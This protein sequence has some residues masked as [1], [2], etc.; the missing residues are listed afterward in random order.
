MELKDKIIRSYRMLLSRDSHLLVADANERSITHRLAMYL[1]NEFPEYDI[2]CEYNR[3]GLEPKRLDSFKKQIDSD[4]TNGA[5]V[6]P[7]IIVHHRG[8][9]DNFIVIEAKKS[10]NPRNHRDTGECK[11]DYCK[12]RAYKTDLSYRHAFFIKFPVGDE[13]KQ[14]SYS[15]ITDYIA[16]I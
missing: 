5:T 1:Q 6:F 8:T 4:E 14:L 16:E 7:D 2:D 10:S 13:L 12:L 11:C 9:H 15:A 3:D